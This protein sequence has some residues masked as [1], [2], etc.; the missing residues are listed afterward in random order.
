VPPHIKE[1]VDLEALRK[2]H[3]QRETYRLRTNTLGQL[4]RL[5][6]DFQFPEGNA[7]DCWNQWNVGNR[8][9]QIPP[10]RLVDVREYQFLD[11]KATSYEEKWGQRGT[12]INKRQPSWKICSDMKVL[13]N[14]IERKASD[15]GLDTSD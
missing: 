4:T 10:S 6:D 1:L 9:R 7:F 13:C 14:C 8:E 2:E 15:A 12:H 5:P 11:L 3:L